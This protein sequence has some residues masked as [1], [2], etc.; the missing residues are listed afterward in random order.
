MPIEVVLDQ[1][2]EAL[3]MDPVEVRMRNALEP[4]KRTGAGQLLHQS[5]GL[6]ECIRRVAEAIKWDEIR[7]GKTQDDPWRRGVGIAL[8]YKNVGLGNADQQDKS[9][10]YV[11]LADGGRVLVRA[12]AAEIG[13]G[14]TTILRQF[15]AET[16][17]VAYEDVDILTGDTFETPDSGVSSASRQTF[18]TGNAVIRAAQDVRRQI[19]EAASDF[20][21][22]PQELLQMKGGK[23]FV[24][25]RPHL[26]M[27]L[28]EIFARSDGRRFDAE[29]LYVPPETSAWGEY[30]QQDYKTHVTYGYGA[31]LRG[32]HRHRTSSE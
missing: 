29:K 8:A 2:A 31:Q 17:G 5:V 12:G 11:A 6:K 20:M 26:A 25:S 27:T 22:V 7:K 16:L 32:C 18:V 14:M 9:R 19:L 13:Q 23:V 30:D 3:G 21:D 1:V 10:A 24:E 4:G 15:A 28:G